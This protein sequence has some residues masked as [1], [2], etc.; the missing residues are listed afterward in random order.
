MQDL[1]NPLLLPKV[2]LVEVMGTLIG[3]EENCSVLIIV[4][5]FAHC[6]EMIQEEALPE[7]PR[8]CT[9]T[10]PPKRDNAMN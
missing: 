6:Q 9:C 10:G 8:T 4:E 7:V 1:T 5:M 2:G 3:W